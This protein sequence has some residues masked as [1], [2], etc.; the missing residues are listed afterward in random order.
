MPPVLILESLRSTALTAE[1][2]SAAAAFVAGKGAVLV[3][4]QR[5]GAERIAEALESPL[6]E[7]AVSVRRARRRIAGFDGALVGPRHGSTGGLHDLPNALSRE[8]D[9]CSD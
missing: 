9:I 4:E 1:I 5:L 3:H 7:L 6:M 2:A 8:P